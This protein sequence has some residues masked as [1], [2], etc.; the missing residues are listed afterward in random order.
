MSQCNRNIRY[1]RE[2]RANAQKVFDLHELRM[3]IELEDISRIRE[4]AWNKFRGC[5]A[6]SVNE[7][8]H[9]WTHV[10]FN[11]YTPTI[12]FQFS[13]YPK[14]MMSDCDILHDLKRREMENYNFALLTMKTAKKKI[15]QSKVICKIVNCDDITDCFHKLK[16][17]KN[18]EAYIEAI[19]DII[20][21]NEIELDSDMLGALDGF[22]DDYEIIGNELV[23]SDNCFTC[24]HCRDVGL[25]DDAVSV[26]T[27][28]RMNMR[29][30]T[31]DEIWCES[32]A[33]NHAFQCSRNNEYY[34][35][36]FYNSAIYGY[37]TICTENADDLYYWESD[38]EYHDEP[39]ED[40]EDECG[41][42]L[43]HGYGPSPK[44]IAT[45]CNGNYIGFEI[46]KNDCPGNPN[47]NE[48]IAHW[49]RD[50]SCGYEAVTNIFPCNAEYRN[51]FCDMV[52]AQGEFIDDM[53]AEK[54]CGGHTTISGNNV[55]W[56][57]V[58]NYMG[59]FY[60]LYKERL[61]NQYC[62]GGKDMKEKPRQKYVPV[63]IR[64][65]NILEFRICSAFKASKTVVFRFD[66]FTQLLN[67]LDNKIQFSDWIKSDELNTLLSSVYSAN[68]ITRIVSDAIL[69]QDWIE[70]GITNEVIRKYTHAA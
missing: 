55:S 35:S 18:G 42:I 61:L 60:S 70:T 64:E 34:R 39:E 38:N 32:C 22:I 62:N 30:N 14:T 41:R 56:W 33:S 51:T 43:D 10:S 69:F 12:E 4:F 36:D 7:T 19:R 44:K 47:P 49:E 8:V 50:G 48:F 63:K 57:G 2:D 52:K 13:Y 25:N 67:C 29:Y 15:H 24:E 21:D 58:R 59:L 27:M 37:D 6:F 40:E 1:A 54:D 66:L 3:S 28:C 65:D 26:H 31:T 16:Q 53:K 46:E 9:H 5:D 11:E 45:S 23:S 20:V 17:C 68:K